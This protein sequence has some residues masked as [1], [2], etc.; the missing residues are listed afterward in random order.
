MLHG[1]VCSACGRV[2][3]VKHEADAEEEAARTETAWLRVTLRKVNMARTQKPCAKRREQTLA[4]MV[5][6]VLMFFFLEP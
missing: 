5:K 4:K 1:R 6:G 2:R 3:R